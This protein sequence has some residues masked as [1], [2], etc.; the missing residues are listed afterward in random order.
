MGRNSTADWDAQVRVQNASSVRVV[1]IGFF[2]EASKKVCLEHLKITA[3]CCSHH[4]KCSTGGG[5]FLRHQPD[6]VFFNTTSC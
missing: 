3:D 1:S 4:S 6:S 2:N 5:L